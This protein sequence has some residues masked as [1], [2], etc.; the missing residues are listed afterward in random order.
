MIGEYI[1]KKARK[2]ETVVLSGVDDLPNPQIVY[3]SK[4]N[5]YSLKK[6]NQM[7]EL[8]NFGSIDSIFYCQIR[9]DTIVTSSHLILNQ[10]INFKG[11]HFFKK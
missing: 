9:K 2:N 4:R 8:V 6:S 5:F 10:Q 11:D 1:H 3:Y 7:N